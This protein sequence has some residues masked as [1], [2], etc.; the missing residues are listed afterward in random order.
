MFDNYLD[1]Y[2]D[3]SNDKNDNVNIN[4]NDNKSHYEQGGNNSKGTAEIKQVKILN[5]SDRTF[6]PTHLPT[7]LPSFESS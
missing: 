1:N 7:M 4:N 3:D 6:L 2:V 5:N